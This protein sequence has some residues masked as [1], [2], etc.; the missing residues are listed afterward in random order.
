MTISSVLSRDYTRPLAGV[1]AALLVATAASTWGL[2]SV[3]ATPVP[4]K[5]NPVWLITS[6]L[7]I[8]IGLLAAYHRDKQIAALRGW[9][10]ETACF[11]L[12]YGLLVGSLFPG[13]GSFSVRDRISTYTPANG[14]IATSL[15]VIFPNGKAEIPA[16]EKSRL[17]D[18][19]AIYRDCEMSSLVVRG[20]SSS[21]AFPDHSDEQ[22]LALANVRGNAVATLL[23]QLLKRNVTA[24]PW[25]D[26]G[27]MIRFR[28]VRDFDENNRRLLASERYNRRVEIY[29]NDRK[30]LPDGFGS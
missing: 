8:P 10:L 20:F 1:I 9:G 4:L 19:L 2:Y 17:E 7:L 16:P 21:A 5:T 29:W 11:L 25:P 22:N 13:D 23:T 24:E 14:V 3:G 12:A 26:F 15:F 28:R 30:C 18:E 6:L 27:S